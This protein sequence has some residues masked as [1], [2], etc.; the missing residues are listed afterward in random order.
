MRQF[1][2]RLCACAFKRRPVRRHLIGMSRILFLRSLRRA[3]GVPTT[4]VGTLAIGVGAL[5]TAFALVDAALWRPP[6]FGEAGRI[7]MLYTTRASRGEPPRRERWSYPRIELLKNLVSDIATIANYTP[8]TLA[9]TG[10]TEP[11]WLTGEIVSPS[12]FSILKVTPLLGRTFHATE[13]SQDGSESVVVLGHALWQRRFGGDPAVLGR[14]LSLR[15]EPVTVVGVMPARFRGLTDKAQYWIPTA[16]AS[17]VSYAEY[18]TTSQSFI[19]VVGRLH[20]GVQPRQA[21][22]KLAGLGASINAA[23]PAEDPDPEEVVSATAVSLN[24]A[25]I[26]K[27]MKRS[28]LFILSAV[29]LLYLLACANAAN[30]LFGRAVARR[31]EA[32]IR[33]A[34]GA[35]AR[36]LVQHFLPE[37][38]VLVL[39]AGAA[40]SALAWV[41]IHL[42][43]PPT[44]VWGPRTFYGSIGAFAE[45]RFDLRAIGFAAGLTALTLLLVAWVST[46]SVARLELLAAL[47]QGER[48]VAAR[49]GTLRRPTLRGA[50]VAV[51]AA[52]ATLLLVGGGLML[53]SYLRMRRTDLGVDAQNVLTFWI[54]PSEVRIPPEAAPAFISRVLDA[55]QRVP[56][57]VAATVD[58]G[59]PTAG[60]ARSTLFI[61]GR[62]APRP[63]DAPPVLRHYIAPDHFRVLGVPLVRGRVFDDGDVAGRPRVAIISESAARRFWP[64]EDPIGQRVW[65]GGG[66]SFSDPDSSA[67]I[68]GIV[69]DVVHEPLDVGSNRNDFYTPYA[70]FTYASRQVMVRTTA[71][72]MAAFSE[73]RAAV[74]TVDPDLPLV[75]VK[76][77]TDLIGSSWSRQRF[78]ARL[79][80]LFAS[81]ALLLATTG[82]YAVVAYAVSQRTRELGIRVALGARPSSILRLV[83]AEGM[84]FPLLGLAAG[85]A[86]ALALTRF[87]QA[88]LYEVR[89]T[90]PAVFAATA[91]V[92][93]VAAAL[94]CLGPARRA[95]RQ[96]PLVALR[97][98]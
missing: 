10:G 22:S 6:P 8:S 81:I 26:E 9:I 78:D 23:I 72:P 37:A 93:A 20:D 44:E 92:L 65:F 55:I 49:A 43:D 70:Q 66:S 80:V 85:S 30:L 76:P 56:G 97:A 83:M 35:N 90:E 51:E 91:G 54:R 57:V 32:A 39:A 79:S 63:Q 46:A 64:D 1:V 45:P 34:L 19:N 84:A 2:C 89:P 74:R 29:A 73:I 96:D 68:V 69:K 15:G 82:I 11:E 14:T 59:A 40:G 3:P 87:L 58:G 95:M 24:E 50:I 42:V 98:E 71:D 67:E 16:L 31:R 60:S 27:T 13:D 38:I 17:R 61:A 7:V 77:L 21:D 28:L 62:P 94:A 36:R 33:V 18:L 41:A 75:E 4:V 88:A 5:V 12:Y 86:G 52:L 25:R 48:G 47:R 53:D